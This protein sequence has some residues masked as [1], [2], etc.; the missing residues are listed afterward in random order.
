MTANPWDK[1][2]WNDW[3]NDP[4][5]RLC[6]LAAQGLWMRCLCICAK[7]DPKGYLAVAGRSL[8]PADLGTLVGRQEHEVETLLEE[9]AANGVYSRDRKGRIYSRRMVRNE[10]KAALARKNGKLGGNPKLLKQREISSS[11]IPP[12][13]VEANPHKPEANSHKQLEPPIAPPD[14]GSG[15]SSDKGSKRKSKRGSRLPDDWSPDADLRDWARQ[16]LGMTDP[17]ID[18]HTEEFRDYWR[19]VPGQRGCKLDWEATWR[20]RMRQIAQNLGKRNGSAPSSGVDPRVPAIDRRTF[21][22]KTFDWK[23]HPILPDWVLQ[24]PGN[25]WRYRIGRYLATGFWDANNWGPRTGP[26]C[27]VPKPIIDE[28]PEFSQA[29]PLN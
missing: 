18:F 7:S 9:L 12:D 26:D 19:G 17:G 27:E 22:P 13:R 5:L 10:K 23:S 21:N 6:S 4:G 15:E 14:G 11:D 24:D 16:T 29:S 25:R 28:F 20:N 3:D 1:F 8:S 2:F